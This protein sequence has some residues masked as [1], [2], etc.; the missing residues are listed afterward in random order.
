M[1]TNGTCEVHSDNLTYTLDSNSQI[2]TFK[3]NKGEVESSKITSL[4]S[5]ELVLQND[6]SPVTTYYKRN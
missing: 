2:L 3:N 1:H 4:S 6:G 5:S